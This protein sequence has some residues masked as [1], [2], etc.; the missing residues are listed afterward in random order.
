MLEAESGRSPDRTVLGRTVVRL[1]DEQYWLY[2]AVDP[3]T[4]RFPH[5]RLLPPHT[6]S[7]GEGFLAE[8]LEKH[9]VTDAVFLIDGAHDL[10]GTLR[11]T[12]LEYRVEIHGL[13]T[14]IERVFRRIKHR[15]LSFSNFFS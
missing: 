13:R 7:I 14:R 5:V 3:E 2:A 1:N 11:R 12:G 15:T 8:L 10:D 6:F 4:N 9:D